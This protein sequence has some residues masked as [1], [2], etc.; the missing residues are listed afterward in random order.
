[1]PHTGSRSNIM[2]RHVA[3]AS[4]IQRL[5]MCSE[6]ATYNANNVFLSSSI[7]C[8]KVFDEPDPMSLAA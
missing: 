7:S 3:A 5:T 8:L 4:M 2:I 1:M 6:D